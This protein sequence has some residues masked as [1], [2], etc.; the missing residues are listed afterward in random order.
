MGLTRLTIDYLVWQTSLF[1][2]VRRLVLGYLLLTIILFNISQ[3]SALL[4]FFLPLKVIIMVA[5]DGIPRYLRF[6]VTPENRNL[7][8]VLFS[9]LAVGFYLLH[10]LCDYLSDIASQKAAIKILAR[11][12]KITL[13]DNEN[14]LAK[15]FFLKL[16]CNIG[17]V[18]MVVC[19]FALGLYLSLVLFG[20]LIAVVI[21]EYIGFG[22]F[23]K[24]YLRPGC[25]DARIKF[26]KA[27]PNRLNFFSS[28]NFFVGFCL[29]IYVFFNDPN[30]GLLSGLLSFILF[31][32][33]M[34]KIQ[35]AF[36]DVF[37]LHKNRA[38]IDAL[39]YTHI[40]YEAPVSH[41]ENSFMDIIAPGNREA[42]L[43]ALARNHDIVIEE[44]WTWLD[45]PG[46]NVAIFGANEA[47]SEKAIYVKIYG[48]D[49]TLRSNY[50]KMILDA[51]SKKSFLIPTLVFEYTYS[52]F[53]MFVYQDLPIFPIQH[54]GKTLK[55][56]MDEARVAMWQLQPDARLVSQCSRTKPLLPA[57]LSEEKLSQLLIAACT[58]QEKEQV[59][60]LMAA[61]DH[62]RQLLNRMPLFVFNPLLNALNLMM[63]SDGK[64]MLFSWTQWSLEPIGVGLPR[65][66]N[67][68]YLEKILKQASEKRP[69][70]LEVT[71]EM[72]LITGYASRLD[73]AITMQ[74]FRQGLQLVPNLLDYLDR[75]KLSSKQLCT[76]D[77]KKEDVSELDFPGNRSARMQI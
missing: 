52:G 47:D 63:R 54:K 43:T 65:K 59:R 67:Q 3:V 36:K 2:K 12:D 49:Q 20:V 39:F 25:L 68:A 9:M 55:N 71:P 45:V 62:L 38:K 11:A 14:Q 16:S 1:R 51:F 6:I 75:C 35:A 57:R 13:F 41:T 29:L 50:E 23:W 44:N 69:D 5:S 30:F 15:E 7:S 56:A 70:L 61:Y 17:T 4:A 74:N 48:T 46:K 77:W 37:F 19:G 64:P 18:L 32:Q 28:F 73:I 42:W 66:T 58:N 31:R 22:F 40:H 8:I 27:L 72:V 33:I 76:F 10:L 24:R 21:I 53:K 60:R 26:V 34:T